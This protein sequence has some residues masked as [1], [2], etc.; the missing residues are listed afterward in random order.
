MG[1]VI[2]MVQLTW[3]FHILLFFLGPISIVCG[4]L[5]VLVSLPFLFSLIF[6]TG[7]L[8]ALLRGLCK[9]NFIF[10]VRGQPLVPLPYNV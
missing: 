5:L 8:T 9:K 3:E 6:P 1:Q 7:L 4:F 10:G 2:F